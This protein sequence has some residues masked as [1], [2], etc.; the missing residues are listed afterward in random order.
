MSNLS[1]RLGP[2]NLARAVGFFDKIAFRTRRP[3]SKT[4]MKTL[5]ANASF[6][7]VRI[8]HPIRNSP[9]ALI[10]TVVAP[11]RKALELLAECPDLKLNY[12]EVALDFLA[13]DVSAA[14]LLHELFDCGF[15]QAWHGKRETRRVEN[16]TYTGQK[17]PGH[18]FVWYSDRASKVAPWKSCLHVEGRHQGMAAVRRIGI[19]TPADL[20]TFD[21][22][23]YWR[24]YLNLYHIDLARLGRF[25]RNR[26]R[27]ERRKNTS[28]DVSG[29]FKFDVDHRTGGLLFRIFS[30]HAHQPIRSVQRFVDQYGRGP[31][32]KKIDMSS[33]VICDN[34]SRDRFSPFSLTYMQSQA[35]NSQT[36]ETGMVCMAE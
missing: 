36:I 27:R 5:S 32:L 13:E 22:T 1:A 18:L 20:L 3:L 23:A 29:R 26:T 9:D 35:D 24:R 2:I 12:V 10:V 34:H 17:K 16:G 30:A 25:H 6:V 11:R 21:H 14:Y 7:D 33:I 28:I 4:K 19:Q 31:F 8:G 15:V